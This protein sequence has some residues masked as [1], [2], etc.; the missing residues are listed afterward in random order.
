V[1]SNC[2]P[3]SNSNQVSSLSKHKKFIKTKKVVMAFGGNEIKT[4]KIARLLSKSTEKCESASIRLHHDSRISFA[5]VT[6]VERR[7]AAQVAGVAAVNVNVLPLVVALVPDAGLLGLVS[8]S[9]ALSVMG[10]RRKV[11]ELEKNQSRK[12]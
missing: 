11:S 9:M 3:F 1:K 7:C 5:S 10:G 4:R 6:E 2:D 8:V 12:L